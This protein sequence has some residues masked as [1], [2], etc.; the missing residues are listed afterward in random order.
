MPEEPTSPSGSPK[1]PRYAWSP[2]E[3]ALVALI[4]SPLPG[5]V[6]HALNYARLGAPGRRKLAL[7]SNL[8]TGMVLL[9]P[10]RIPS[11]QISA[12]LLIAAYFYKT[13]EHLFL[14]HRSSGGRKASL[15]VPVVLTVVVA[16][17]L[18]V[19]FVLASAR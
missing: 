1:E 10:L 7:F 11:L 8:I 19:G 12:N 16:S 15:V 17:I 13:Q 6:L 14:A 2:T 5:G 3:I 18:L 9:L 4:L